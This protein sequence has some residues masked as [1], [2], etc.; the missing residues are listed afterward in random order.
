MLAILTC[1]KNHYE[2]LCKRKRNN[3][4][5]SKQQRLHLLCK[6]NKRLFWKEIKARDHDD[7]SAVSDK[8]SVDQ[9]HNYFKE[10]H[11]V[12]DVND[13]GY[14]PMG[15]PDVEELDNDIQTQEL[16]WAVQ[17]LQGGKAPGIDGL[18]PE[19]FT[20]LDEQSLAFLCAT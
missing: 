14:N 4:H 11:Q 2:A 6:Q 16:T 10:L 9:W 3:H 13:T 8:I 18:V 12:A 1:K 5:F 15:S 7:K 17:S 19:L 20:Y